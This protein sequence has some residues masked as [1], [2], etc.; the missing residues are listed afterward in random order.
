MTKPVHLGLDEFE[1][2]QEYPVNIYTHKNTWVVGRASQMRRDAPMIWVETEEKI[3]GGTSGSP[4]VND[5]GELVGIV[6][7]FP[8]GDQQKYA[9]RAPLPLVALPVWILK[10]IQQSRMSSN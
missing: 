5:K 9:G 1:L 3:E 2:F 6:S 4:I 8:E 10:I 7:N